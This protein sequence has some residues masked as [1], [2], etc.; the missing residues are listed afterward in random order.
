MSFSNIR[1]ISP[2][3]DPA[4]LDC[5]EISVTKYISA[6][7]GL[8]WH[9]TPVAPGIDI[10]SNVEPQFKFVVTNI[11]NVPLTLVSLSDSVYGPLSVGG[12][13]APGEFFETVITKPW[14]VGLHE[15]KAT[16]T[17][18]FGTETVSGTAFAHYNGVQIDKS[19]IQIVKYVS[20]DGG[21]TWTDA[22]FIPGPKI[23][24][25]VSPKFKFVVTNIGTEPLPNIAVSDDVYGPIGTSAFLAP[26]VSTA[27]YY[28][29]PWALGTHRNQ[30]TVTSAFGVSDHSSAYYTGVEAAPSITLQKYVSPDGGATWE[31]AEFPPGPTIYSDVSP[32]FMFVVTN[33]GNVPL[34]DITVKDSAYGVIGLV[35]TLAAGHKAVFTII[36]PWQAGAHINIATV[37][38]TFDTQTITD[39]DMAHYFGAN[40]GISITK[41]VS[42]DNGAT[43]EDA[44]TPPGPRL[45]KG[46]TPRFKY[47]VKNSGNVQLTNIVVTDNVLGDIG[48]LPEL[49]VGDSKIFFA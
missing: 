38:S 14:G 42:V 6:D 10:S 18:S 46:V 26:G 33:V 17:G 13:L 8:S 43:W 3:A 49:A 31:D 48:T 29:A 4:P 9:Y 28:T 22:N 41:Y 15:N 40:P 44:N 5:P 36:T 1:D 35:P 24:S 19:A 7:G 12:N 20:P 11:G 45:L 34:T 32:Q 23:Y 25:N 30:A 21:T 39:S 47:E 37:I 2:A 16:A 27:F